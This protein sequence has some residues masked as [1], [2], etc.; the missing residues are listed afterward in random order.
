MLNLNR[1]DEPVLN[2]YTIIIANEDYEVIDIKLEQ[3]IDKGWIY[4][5][6][7]D[8]DYQRRLSIRTTKLNPSITPYD[9]LLSD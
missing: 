6:G 1:N 2:P 9:E 4:F 5:Q 8:S 7:S 3:M